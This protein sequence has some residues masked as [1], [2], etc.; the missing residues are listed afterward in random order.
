LRRWPEQHASLDSLFIEVTGLIRNPMLLGRTLD[1]KQ[2][3]LLCYSNAM[4]FTTNF[5]SEMQ[6]S[7]VADYVVA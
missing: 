1:T 6:I 5:R 2:L 7:R 3:F 4:R